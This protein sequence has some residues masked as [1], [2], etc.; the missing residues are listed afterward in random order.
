GPADAGPCGGLAPSR[1]NSPAADGDG[2][3]AAAASAA[4]RTMRLLQNHSP[5]ETDL[6]ESQS[7]V[8]REDRVD[9]GR[10]GSHVVAQDLPEDRPIV[11]A[12]EE[13]TPRITEHDSCRPGPRVA[14][15]NATVH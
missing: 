10:I 14:V 11:G 2:R 1:R 12:H 8:P 3:S 13:I 6:L 9:L 15:V 5:N 7:G 4:V